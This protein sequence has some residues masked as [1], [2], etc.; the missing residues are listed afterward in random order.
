MVVTCG[1]LQFVIVDMLYCC[2]EDVLGG[3][4]VS[5]L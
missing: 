3:I 4:F 2:P 5:E 1:L